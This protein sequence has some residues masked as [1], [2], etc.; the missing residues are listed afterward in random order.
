[1]ES[2]VSLP[3]SQE[4]PIGPHPKPYPSFLRSIFNP[5]AYYDGYKRLYASVYWAILPTQKRDRK[6]VEIVYIEDNRCS[7]KIRMTMVILGTYL[8][9]GLQ[10][11]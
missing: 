8:K 11:I 9:C 6:K 10:F 4:P 5:L 2:Q 3:C 7:L 1:M